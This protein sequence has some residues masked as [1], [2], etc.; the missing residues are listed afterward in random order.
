M[1]LVAR[2]IGRGEPEWVLEERQES[3]VMNEKY[4][5]RWNNCEQLTHHSPSIKMGIAI[6][7]YVL[8]RQLILGH[9]S[10]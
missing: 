9:I 2:V 4:P 3:A 8:E 5:G 10:S 6:A 1:Q 7:W